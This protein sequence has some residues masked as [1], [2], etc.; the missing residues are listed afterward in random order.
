[1]SFRDAVSILSYFPHSINFLWL[2]NKIDDW[3]FPVVSDEETSLILALVSTSVKDSPRMRAVGGYLAT[4]PISS[5]S[6]ASP[7]LSH[8]AEYPVALEISLPLRI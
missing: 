7:S 8:I 1:L 2:Y 5:Y 6:H 3:Y 4:G